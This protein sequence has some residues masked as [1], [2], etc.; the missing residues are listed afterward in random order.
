MSTLDN[1]EVDITVELGATTMPIHHLLRMGRG[2]V[3]ELDALEDDP[4][5]IYANNTL[6]AHGEVT[7]EDGHLRV[8]ISH[9]A[10]RRG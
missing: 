1:I 3:I 5:N 10:M 8:V 7:V 9:K 6:I 4:L 2:A